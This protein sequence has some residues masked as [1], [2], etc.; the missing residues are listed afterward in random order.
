MYRMYGITNCDSVK[1]ALDWFKT[2]HVAFEFHDYK[3]KGIAAGQLK[4]WCR[5]VSW[6]LLLN[7]KGTTWRDLDESVKASILTEAD[8]IALMKE[9][10]SLIKR[11]VIEAGNK[12]I[13][14]GFDES[15]YAEAM[16]V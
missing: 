9:H 14:V 5:Q 13:A 3:K 11:P 10:T 2:H 6:E 7:K 4:K 15:I 16:N 12:V 1:K 8:A